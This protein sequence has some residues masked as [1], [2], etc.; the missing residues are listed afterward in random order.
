MRKNFIKSFTKGN[1]ITF[2]ITLLALINTTLMMLGYSPLPISNEK[3]EAIVSIV[4][5]LASLGLCAYNNFNLTKESQTVNPIIDLA[6]V[7]SVSLEE[8]K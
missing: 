5:I 6:K 4:S 3:V 2:L 7:G 8:F 1:V